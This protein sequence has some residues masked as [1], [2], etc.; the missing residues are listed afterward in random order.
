MANF[1]VDQLIE[2]V[3]LRVAHVMHSMWEENGCS[4]TR[5]LDEPFIPD[6]YVVVGESIRGT[7]CREHVIPRR[8]ICDQCHVMFSQGADVA[9]VAAF[10]RA[11]LK[12]IRISREER[13]MLDNVS[14]LNLKQRMPSGWSFAGGDH[15]ARLKLANIEFR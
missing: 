3:F 8:V 2:R 15:F 9:D 14:Q 4:D 10:I 11:S 1:T 7:E 13:H 5:L 12:V 6:K